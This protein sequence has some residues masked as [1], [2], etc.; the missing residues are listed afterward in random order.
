[1][2]PIAEPE[3]GDS[4]GEPISK[5][6]TDPKSSQ[7]QNIE[8]EGESIVSDRGVSEKEAGTPIKQPTYF[9]LR[10]NLS[11]FFGK[12]FPSKV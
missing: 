8:A 11:S 1:M 9:D 5:E 4:G 12:E 7:N 3:P 6:L 2:D 10:N